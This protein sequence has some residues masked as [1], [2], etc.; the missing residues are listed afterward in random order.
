MDLSTGDGDE[1]A[2]AQ[3]RAALSATPTFYFAIV[4]LRSQKQMMQGPGR[5]TFTFHACGV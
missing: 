1:H 2:S 3:G 5:I 4:V